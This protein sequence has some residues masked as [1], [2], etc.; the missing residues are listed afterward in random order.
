MLQPL[1]PERQQPADAAD[2]KHSAESLAWIKH[3]MV[4]NHRF[5]SSDVL[6]A[7]SEGSAVL[8]THHLDFHRLSSSILENTEHLLVPEVV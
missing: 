7:S 1:P 5:S 6:R 8:N 4:L 2:G 3:W